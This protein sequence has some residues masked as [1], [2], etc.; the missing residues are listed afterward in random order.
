[1]RST[2]FVVLGCLLAVL[3]WPV[4]PAAEAVPNRLTFYAPVPCGPACAHWLD[5]TLDLC[6]PDDDCNP[7]GEALR[8]SAVAVSRAVDPCSSPSPSS[9][10]ADAFIGTPPP[11][12]NRLLFVVEPEG[13]WDLLLCA[14]R[15]P[16]ATEFERDPTDGGT[17]WRVEARAFK[18]R[19]C[20]TPLGSAVPVGCAD[21]RLVRV[22]QDTA[23]RLVAY[24]VA[25][26]SVAP[27]YYEWS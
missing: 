24:N 3:A 25:G 13:E 16:N 11:G 19:N 1:M 12:A 22:V 10:Y 2:R 21:G 5:S 8:S 17:R 18:T 20:G 6:R 7:R 14:L 15:G 23:Y 26:A 27:G 4:A 9:S